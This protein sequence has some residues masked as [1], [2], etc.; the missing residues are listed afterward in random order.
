MLES[1]VFIFSLKLEQLKV[2]ASSSLVNLKG[3]QNFHNP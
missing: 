2:D 1:S 3:S